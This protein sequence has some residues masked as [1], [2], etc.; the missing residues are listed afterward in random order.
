MPTANHALARTNLAAAIEAG[1]S[2][3]LLESAVPRSPGLCGGAIVLRYNPTSPHPLMTHFRND[4]LGGFHKGNYFDA[5]D[6]DSAVHDF[7]E[8]VRR[9]R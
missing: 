9:E 3:T 6:I 5:E 1:K 8:R 7:H 4:D 2:A